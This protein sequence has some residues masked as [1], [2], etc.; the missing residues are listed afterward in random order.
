MFEPH[1]VRG[2]TTGS[3]GMGSMGSYMDS[4]GAI[5]MD[6][7]FGKSPGGSLG[8]AGLMAQTVPVVTAPVAMQVSFCR[9]RLSLPVT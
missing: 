6:G 9:H 2:L 5:L 7:R 1:D 4:I 8:M 3:W